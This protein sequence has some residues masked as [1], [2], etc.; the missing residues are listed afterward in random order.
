M[1]SLKE[2][3]SVFLHK[4]NDDQNQVYALCEIMKVVGG[5]SQLMELPVTALNEILGYLEFVAKEQG[6][7]LN[8]SKFK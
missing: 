7:G 1:T 2:L 8:K 3:R 4:E 6:K 5:Y